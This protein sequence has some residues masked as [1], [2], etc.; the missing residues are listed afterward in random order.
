MQATV[1]KIEPIRVRPAS[2]FGIGVR[3]DEGRP[4]REAGAPPAS[5][6]I[7]EMPSRRRKPDQGAPAD[8]PRVLYC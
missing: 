4:V 2:L 5:P 8:E 1:T 3:E 7:F 6:G